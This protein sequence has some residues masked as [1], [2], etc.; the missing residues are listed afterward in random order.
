MFFFFCVLCAVVV[1]GGWVD[2]FMGLSTGSWVILFLFCFFLSLLYRPRAGIVQRTTINNRSNTTA[3]AAGNG[4]RANTVRAVL[5]I[6][7]LLLCCRFGL[8]P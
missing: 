4:R 2:R 5:V 3:T 8:V 6:L 1:Q 7:P